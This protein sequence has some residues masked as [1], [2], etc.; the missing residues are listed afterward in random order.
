MTAT[1]GCGFSEVIASLESEL[2]SMKMAHEEVAQDNKGCYNLIRAKDREL[3]AAAVHL[4]QAR[5]VMIENKASP[6]GCS[7]HGAS[8]SF[9]TFQ[10][11]SISLSAVVSP[12]LRSE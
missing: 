11:S 2:R 6:V 7:T 1:Q 12:V 9:R 5:A 4:E 8:S 10:E 3:D